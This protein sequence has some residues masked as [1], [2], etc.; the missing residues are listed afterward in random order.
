M[1][2]CCVLKYCQ[3]NETRVKILAKA[4]RLPFK[5]LFEKMSEGR[6]LI[7]HEAVRIQEATLGCL[8]A[9]E[10]PNKVKYSD[11]GPYYSQVEFCQCRELKGKPEYKPRKLQEMKNCKKN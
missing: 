7:D 3:H 8:I 1:L 11:I 9:K 6:I 2:P 5:P 10:I 4:A